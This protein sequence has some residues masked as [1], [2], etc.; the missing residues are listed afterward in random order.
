LEIA[1]ALLLRHLAKSLGRGPEWA[2]S[3]VRLKDE[4]LLIQS[5][6]RKNSSERN[7]AI[8]GFDFLKPAN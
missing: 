1:S 7:F 2:M 8:V 5:A 3:R 6:G 4:N